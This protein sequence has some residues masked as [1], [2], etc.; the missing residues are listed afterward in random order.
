[1]IT[2]TTQMRNH[3]DYTDEEESHKGISVQGTYLQDYRYGH[4]GAQRVGSWILRG[5]I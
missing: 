1:M 2:Q 3:T 4:E 5:S